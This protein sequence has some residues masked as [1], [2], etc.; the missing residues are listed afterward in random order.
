M[1]DPAEDVA[2]VLGPSEMA[3]LRRLE[4]THRHPARGLYPGHH[5]SARSSRS[6]E[7]ADFRP[8]APGDDIR[9]IDWRAYGRLGRLMLRTYVAEEEAGVNVVIDASASMGLGDPPKWEAARRL[10]AATALLGLNGSDRVAVGVMGGGDG[11]TP[12]LRLGGGTSRVLVFLAGVDPAG[13]AGP[14]A[15]SKLRWLR[16]GV[17]LVISDFM[18]EPAWE[19]AL[20]ALARAG[21]EVVLWQVLAPDEERPQLRGDVRLVDAESGTRREMTI[22]SRVVADYVRALEALREDL[23]RQA[24]AAGGRFLHTTSDEDLEASMLA[25]LR[26][27]VVKRS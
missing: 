20:V 18:V 8:Y 22:T 6:P 5:R 25:A 21:Q 1:A 2:E 7:F 3:L 24:S 12:H 19:P 9:Q 4:L 17:T 13:I 23:Q 15:L 27:G 26:A 14:A 11:F 16:P 10:G